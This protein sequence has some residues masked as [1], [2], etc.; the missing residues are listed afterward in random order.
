MKA[1]RM[2]TFQ[3][4]NNEGE[5]KSVRVDKANILKLAAGLKKAG[6][7][8]VRNSFIVSDTIVIGNTNIIRKVG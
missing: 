1:V 4:K 7:K 8:I 3:V 6:Y 5:V 2:V